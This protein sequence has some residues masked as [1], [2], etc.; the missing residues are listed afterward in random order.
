[1][2]QGLLSTIVGTIFIMEYKRNL[3]WSLNKANRAYNPDQRNVLPLKFH[4]FQNCPFSS[5][6]ARVAQVLESYF[7][8][9]NLQ[10]FCKFATDT[11]IQLLPFFHQIVFLRKLFLPLFWQHLSV[12]RYQYFENLILKYV[13]QVEFRLVLYPNHPLPQ[14]KFE[15]C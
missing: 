8:L 9:S 4:N 5:N 3:A 10:S 7:Y 11:K 15:F 2:S 13:P 14:S 6:I 1:M 12:R